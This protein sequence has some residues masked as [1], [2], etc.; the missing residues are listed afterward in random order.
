[1]NEPIQDRWYSRGYLPHRDAPGLAQFLTFRLADS[2]PEASLRRISSELEMLPPDERTLRRQRRLAALEDAG[3]GACVLRQQ[4]PE[5][6]RH[7]LVGGR[8]LGLGDD[9][10]HHRQRWAQVMDGFQLN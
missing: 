8:L 10:H 6:P 1:M 4:T 9:S 5:R 7:G 2:L 3:I